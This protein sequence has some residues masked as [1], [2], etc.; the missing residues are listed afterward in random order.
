[1]GVACPVRGGGGGVLSSYAML[2]IGLVRHT[3]SMYA[4]V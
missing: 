2:L 1:M 4:N 3:G